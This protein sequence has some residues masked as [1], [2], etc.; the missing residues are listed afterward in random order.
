MNSSDA[1]N[2]QIIESLDESSFK[3]FT[4]RVLGDL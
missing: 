4:N 3:D 2:V 1:A